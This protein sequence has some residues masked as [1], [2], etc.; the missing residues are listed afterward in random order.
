MSGELLHCAITCQTG[1][2]QRRHPSVARGAQDPR[3]QL[4]ADAASTP[5][6]LYAEGR[7]SCRASLANEPQF[8]CAPKFI[9]GEIAENRSPHGKAKLGIVA[10]EVVGY[11]H[12]ETVVPA[13]YVEAQKMVAE[14]DL[15]RGPQ[16]ADVV[17]LV[18]DSLQGS[19]DLLLC[20]GCRTSL[21]WNHLLKPIYKRHG[22][23]GRSR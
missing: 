16:F 12:R 10:D 22:E 13:I 21:R 9:P 11:S 14:S 7:F 2:I 23:K 1:H 15:V 6:R 20:T 3:H 17:R 19:F 8:A 5:P 18:R 4:S